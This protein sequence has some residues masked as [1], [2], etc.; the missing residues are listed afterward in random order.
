MRRFP[1]SVGTVILGVIVCLLLLNTLG[2]PSPLQ[3]TVETPR[4][5]P[6]YMPGPDMCRGDPTVAEMFTMRQTAIDA[7]DAIDAECA[8]MTEDQLA[9]CKVPPVLHLVLGFPGKFDFYAYVAVKSAHDRLR[10]DAIYI[11]VFGKRFD[12]SPFLQRAIREFGIKL[13]SARDVHEVMGRPVEIVEHQSDVIRLE[14]IIRFGGVYMDLDV[15]VLHPL[16]VFYNNELTMPAEGDVAVNNGIIIAKRCSRF[17]RKWYSEY[18]TFDDSKWGDHSVLLPK[19]M[20]AEY[21]D[22]IHVDQD[23]LQSDWTDSYDRLAKD[24]IE[25][26]YWRPVRA[27]HSFIR[28]AEKRYDEESIK[29]VTS[30][31][32]NMVRRIMAGKPGMW[33]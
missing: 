9:T 5:G 8:S 32:G 12:P 7:A 14:S 28:L 3:S 17:L 11:H 26:D 20:A 1:R 15:F 10:P 27:I 22:L 18:K 23:V 29:N 25:E 19:K 16:D 4:K 33:D 6:T 31:F 13:V 30:N 24:V 2:L 21:P